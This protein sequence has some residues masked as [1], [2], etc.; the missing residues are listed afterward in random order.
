MRL[1]ATAFAIL[2]LVSAPVAQ[3]CTA[4]KLVAKDGGVVYGRTME[5]GFDVKSD[6]AVVPAGTEISG[7]LPDG[8]KGIIYTTKYGMVGATAVGLPVI[9]DGINDRGL[10]VGLL[11]FPG[12]ASYP[13]ATPENKSRAMA[14]HELGNWIL[15]NFASVDDVKAALKDVVLVPVMVEAIK[16]P[17]P[18]HFIV[19][20]PSGKAIVIEPLEK[21][22]KVFDNPLGVLTNSPNFEWHTTNLRN[23]MNLM[24]RNAPALDLKGVRLAQFGQGSGMLGLPGDATPPSRFVRAVAYSQS[25]IPAETAKDAVLQAFHILNAFDIPVGVVREEHQGELHTD[26][27]VWSSVANLRDLTWSFRTYNDQ[28]IRTVDVRQALA[29]AK[30]QVRHIT[31]DSVQPVEDVSTNF[32]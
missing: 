9:V 5:F 30:G 20:E 10:A 21:T 4:F 6:V 26:Y 14:P 8:G 32:R 7:S 29:A 3:A 15:G 23:Y 19:Y 28:S 2:S 27:T 12:Y 25:A 24:T 16:Q 31:M 22:L 1:V 13:D 11:Y 17:A 18:V